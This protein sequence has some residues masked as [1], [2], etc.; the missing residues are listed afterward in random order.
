MPETVSAHTSQREAQSAPPLTAEYTD[1]DV[2]P[3]YLNS[4]E[5]ATPADGQ[6]ATSGAVKDAQSSS[7]DRYPDLPS[8]DED[9]LAELSNPS[10]PMMD[11]APSV[12]VGSRLS[13]ILLN[14]K[15]MRVRPI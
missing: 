5:E 3:V 4:A 13:P 11:G 10:F 15:D 6:S 8:L 9:D 2:R 14:I 12:T 7:S 1:P